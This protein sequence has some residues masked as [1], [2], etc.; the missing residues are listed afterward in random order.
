[1]VADGNK[2]FT[3]SGGRLVGLFSNKKEEKLKTLDTGNKVGGGR[4][5]GSIISTRALLITRKHH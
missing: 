3:Q 1:V 5:R 4:A 2:F